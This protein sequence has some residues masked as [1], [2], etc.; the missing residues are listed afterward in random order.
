VN[1]L[2]GLPDLLA[3]LN[4]LRAKGV[5]YIVQHL[6][7]DAIMVSITLLGE[8]IEIEF[9]E[10]RGRKMQNLSSLKD[11]LSFVN[12]LNSKKISSIPEDYDAVKLLKFA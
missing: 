10:R 7:D 1:A 6:R 8:R 5:W 11:L 9:F 2:R 12:F 4:F 3:F